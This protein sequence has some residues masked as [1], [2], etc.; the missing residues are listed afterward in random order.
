M[1][2][3][4][5]G[6]N[7][8]WRAVMINWVWRYD[9]VS[10]SQNQHDGF[11]SILVLFKC[12]TSQLE[13]SRKL[14]ESFSYIVWNSYFYNNLYRLDWVKFVFFAKNCLSIS[15]KSKTYSHAKSIW[16]FISSHHHHKLSISSVPSL[17]GLI[18]DQIHN[19]LVQRFKNC[20][21]KLLYLLKLLLKRQ[22]KVGIQLL[23]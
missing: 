22:L 20:F 16:Q 8:N 11:E 6:R 21:K 23:R 18:L 13:I 2:Y 15:Q 19:S 17:M 1:L 7:P 3:E 10:S 14:S 4:R 9:W 12:C 5:L